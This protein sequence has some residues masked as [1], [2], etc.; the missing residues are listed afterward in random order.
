MKLDNKKAK[1]GC[2]SSAKKELIC[3]G[4]QFLH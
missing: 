2:D 4:L 3:Q 1:L